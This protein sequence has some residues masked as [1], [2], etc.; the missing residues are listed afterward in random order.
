MIINVMFVKIIFT[1]SVIK[2]K[3]MAVFQEHA[4]NHAKEM[5]ATSLTL[6]IQKICPKC[7]L[8]LITVKLAKD[9]I[10]VTFAEILGFYLQKEQV[11]I[12]NVLIA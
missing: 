9:Q 10:Y 3:K 1:S 11:V 2:Q 6:Q 4:I 12:K 7:A 8:A 5:V